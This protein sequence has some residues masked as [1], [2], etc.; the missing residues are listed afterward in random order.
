MNK[1]IEFIKIDNAGKC[2]LTEEAEEML[3]KIDNNLAVICIAGIY[4]SGKSYLLNRLLGRQDGFE[5]GPNISSCTKGL[6]IWGDTIKLKNKNTEV[7]VIDT[8]GLASAFE[9]R[10]ESIDMIIFCLSLLLSSLFIYNSMKNIDESAIENLALVLNFAKKI[11]S[12]FNEINDYANNFPSFL[13]VLRDFALE[14]IDNQGNEVTTKQYLENALKEE[15][16]NMISNSSYNKGII[17]EIN[18]KNDIRKT[19]K[20]FFRERDCYTL[21]R[22][23]HE[24]KK[25]KIIDQLP[26]E[27]L[28][29][30]FLKQMN[31]LVKKIFENIRPK[32]VNGGYMNGP[33]FLNLI[34]MYIN[35]L[36]SD[37]LPDINTSWKIVIDSQ[38]KAAY[39]TGLDYY[40]NEM[41]NLDY[42]NYYT[43]EK[44]YKKHYELRERAM[45]Y[46]MDFS[47]M[48]IPTNTLIEI[49][50]KLDKKLN[51]EFINNYMPKWNDI[52][53]SQCED[54]YIK[55]I[56]VYKNNPELNEIFACLNTIDEVL[57]FIEQCDTNEKKYEV[58]YPKI[59][60]F[61]VDFLK[62]E[63]NENK[64]KN[65]QKINELQ[66]EVIFSQELL[67]KH[68]KI[69]DETR[70][71]YE[72]QIKE[73]KEENLE[74]RIDLEAK[75][76]EKSR[77]LQNLKN[78]SENT[79]EEMKLKIDE[80]NSAILKYQNQEQEYSKDKDKKKK[81]KDVV[82]I[83]ETILAFKLD[84]IANRIDSIQNIFFKN[85]VE[86][87]KN[88][89]LIEMDDKY[90]QVQK[91][92][93]QKLKNAK[94]NCEKALI[95]LKESKDTEI[96]KMK[97][98]IKDLNEEIVDYKSQVDSL[99]YK[100]SLYK[101]KIINYEKEK[102]TQTDQNELLRI[103]AGKLNGYVDL[104]S[105]NK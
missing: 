43:S 75:I 34:K 73:I 69:L 7:L 63:F 87:V 74:N 62:K 95:R 25:L 76:D 54:I 52:C 36:N 50:Q 88:K 38:L 48:N 30:E 1:P 6:W 19:L 12:K 49:I 45:S 80:L 91:E 10:N 77:I 99:E 56:E 89:M 61:F 67:E 93:K 96:E 86:K 97:Q 84:A 2:T 101:E 66:Q 70:E 71:E 33:M 31:T 90:D 79:I 51:D 55:L 59:I 17:E 21:V 46:I 57:K 72:K 11:Q 68:K 37:N 5:I 32:S 105:K 104:L 28:R 20:L 85:E 26:V 3:S 24:E 64:K 18:K 94:K 78:S 58:M 4:R 53:K 23:V 60:S 102:K 92:F 81:K 27:E 29:P 83:D 65:E 100:I 14:L 82:G 47:N 44:L 35:S 8:E 40:M 103:L 22:P 98:I 13:W 39:N 9:D 15:N 42:K 16:I 41:N